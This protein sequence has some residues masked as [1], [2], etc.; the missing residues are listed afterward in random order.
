MTEDLLKW[1]VPLLAVYGAGLSTYNTWS[2]R[3]QK[4]LAERRTLQ[5]EVARG[6][7]V[8]DD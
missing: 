7:P 5:I 2:A 4:T 6:F 3:R 8:Y 1:F